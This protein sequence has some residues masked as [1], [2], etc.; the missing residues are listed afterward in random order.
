MKAKDV[1]KCA[2][3]RKG[4]MHAGTPL[5]WKIRLQRMGLD[6]R[7][8]EQTAGLEMMMGNV[9]LARV[10][11]PDPDIAKPLTDER[12]VLVCEP[13]AGQQVSV[14]QIGLQDEGDHSSEKSMITGR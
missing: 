11:G 6:R 12:T 7:A 13:C 3:C 1:Q 10:M 2:V 8:I 4:L 14:Y 9:A 5:F